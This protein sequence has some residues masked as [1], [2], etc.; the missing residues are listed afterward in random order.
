MLTIIKIQANAKGRHDIQS[1]QDRSECWEE[2]WIAVPEALAAQVWACRGYCELKIQDGVLAGV[3]PTQR[4]SK[5]EPPGPS[6]DLEQRVTSLEATSATKEDVQA[7]LDSMAA[8][9]NEG[10]QEA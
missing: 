4:L 8:A 3:T 9:Y 6:G 5:P 10:V 2:G 1:Q 7:V